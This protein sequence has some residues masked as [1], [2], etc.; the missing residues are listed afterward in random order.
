MSYGCALL[1]ELEPLIPVPP[2]PVEVPTPQATPLPLS[3]Q[4]PNPSP[5]P[6]ST[7]SPFPV[8]IPVPQPSCVE[9]PAPP[10]SPVSLAFSGSC[11]RGFERITQF[12]AQRFAPPGMILCTVKSECGEDG[13]GACF[14]A[15]DRVSWR[16]AFD[17]D[18]EHKTLR[19]FGEKWFVYDGGRGCGD[20]YGRHLPESSGCSQVYAH[21]D[22]EWAPWDYQGVAHPFRCPPSSVETPVPSIPPS[23]STSCKAVEQTE[24][25]MAPGNKC[26]SYEISGG[27]VRCLVDSTVRPI[28]DT[29][30]QE[31]WLS[32]CGERNH[33]P[34]YETPSGEQ[35]WVLSG[36]QDL[37]PSARNYAQR[38]IT[39]VAGAE[40]GV[41]VCIYPD[42][43]TPDGCKITRRGDGCGS[44]IFNL[45]LQ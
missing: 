21:S 7:P 9:A 27:M 3:T 41:T 43:R 11:P 16:Y 40:V 5:E 29:D 37:G 39:G 26:H 20:A 4:T 31:N 18:H 24:H 22:G 34:D 14:T 17:L 35:R 28:C 38:W 19:K 8:P 32:V 33:D 25:F 1:K 36:A 6:T 2:P 23:S 13:H 42:A 10:P 12:E 45:P 15:G 30:H 44:R